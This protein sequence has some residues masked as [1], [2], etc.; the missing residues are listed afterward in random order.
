MYKEFFF[1]E[2]TKDRHKFVPF[3]FLLVS[4]SLINK[5]IDSSYCIHCGELASSLL[6]SLANGIAAGGAFAPKYRNFGRS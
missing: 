4:A 5:P 3:F 6:Y 1:V 2:S